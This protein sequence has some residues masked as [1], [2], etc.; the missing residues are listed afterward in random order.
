MPRKLGAVIAAFLVCVLMLPGGSALAA[1]NG[2]A[3]DTVPDSTDVEVYAKTAYNYPENCYIAGD[4]DGSYTVETGDGTTLTV[5]L[6]TPDSSLRLVVYRITESDSAAYAW[7]MGCTSG[8]GDS[9]LPYEIYFIDGDGNRV[10]AGSASVTITLPGGYGAPAAYSVTTAGAATRMSAAVSGDTIRFTIPASGYYVLASTSE[11][12]DGDDV[13]TGDGTAYDFEE[14][15]ILYRLMVIS[16]LD[17]VSD[18]LIAAGI[19]SVEELKER[20]FEIMASVLP[21]ATKGNTAYYEVTLM[22]KI[23]GVWYT[24]DEEHFP[25]GGITVTLP[26]PDGT[27]SSYSFTAVHMFSRSV[28]GKTAGEYEIP[29]IT[30][31]NDGL[32]MTLT[33]L[34]PVAVSWTEKDSGSK[35]AE[36]DGNE[37][38][39]GSGSETG[40]ESGSGSGSSDSGSET[41]TSGS[42]AVNPKTGDDSSLSLW[43]GLL[44]ASGCALIVLLFYRRRRRDTEK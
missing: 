4:E 42:S 41:E 10:D 29:A 13:Y 12:E 35:S 34:S 30:K 1:G 19:D 18:D 26:Y 9:R 36:E 11:E 38:D 21:G 25:E 20:L 24:A 22:V 16:D 2:T 33:G 40:S 15:G 37:T 39:G 8:L 32:T 43:I 14:D 5:T 27:D 6:E 3:T 31:G 28:Q 17:S 7:I 44:V 23:D